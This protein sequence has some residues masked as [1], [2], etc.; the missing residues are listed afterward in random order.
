M[1]ASP[2][3]IAID[4]REQL[5]Y[6]FEKIEAPR[7]NSNKKEKLLYLDLPT[8]ITTLRSGD[9][10]IVGHE[11]S[12]AVE[13]KSAEDLYSTVSQGRDRFTRELQRLNQMEIAWVVV[14][15][16]FRE[17]LESPPK[18][19]KFNPTALVRSIDAWQVR[20]P[21]V[22]WWFVP[23]RIAGEVKTFRLLYRWWLEMTERV[24]L[25]KLGELVEYSI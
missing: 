2:F 16:E 19:T 21:R 25:V 7:K 10:S 15:S 23:S 9:Y 1:T 22:H 17:L 24:Q 20:Y 4:T 11:S 18:F 6:A 8:K 14:E 13:R 5:P 3:T 12:V